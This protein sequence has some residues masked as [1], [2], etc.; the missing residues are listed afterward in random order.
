MRCG[1]LFLVFAICGCNSLCD[2]F[3]LN[4]NLAPR[5]R[6]SFAQAINS[7]AVSSSA[8]QTQQIND[9]IQFTI[10]PVT[11]NVELRKASVFSIGAFFGDIDASAF[12]RIQSDQFD[13]WLRYYGENRP[14]TAP[15]SAFFSATTPDG[16]IVGCA[17]VSVKPYSALKSGAL[18]FFN[19]FGDRTKQ[20]RNFDMVPVVANVAVC[21]SQRRQGIG[22]GLAAECEAI[23]ALWG[24]G[25]V[26]LW[27]TSKHPSS[28]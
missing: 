14:N 24:F 28:K 15:K 19:P 8:S 3:S 12:M 21:P 2:A 27:L 1:Y 6:R 17:S 13:L 4:V 25:E 16:R 11:T 20:R 26:R 5:P 7:N 18:T 23:A 22:E 9:R 10:E